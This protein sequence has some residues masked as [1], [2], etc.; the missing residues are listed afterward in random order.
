M[1]GIGALVISVGEE[2]QKS[3]MTY[4]NGTFFALLVFLL[5]FKFGFVDIFDVTSNS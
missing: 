2:K 3:M 4:I 5:L 1:I